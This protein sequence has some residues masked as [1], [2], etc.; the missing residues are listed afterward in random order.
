MPLVNH[1]ILQ[2]KR[3]I[4][5]SIF[6]YQLLLRISFWLQERFGRTRLESQ[7]H[8]LQH[9]R[10]PQVG[11]ARMT[12]KIAT[13]DRKVGDLEMMEEQQ[14]RTTMSI[15]Y[16]IPHLF[17]FFLGL[18]NP[19]INSFNHPLSPVCRARQ[20][21][22]TGPVRHWVAW[23]VLGNLLWCLMA[24]RLNVK[25]LGIRQ[26]GSLLSIPK[27][28]TKCD[29]YLAGGDWNPWNFEWLSRNSWE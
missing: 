18:R 27:V 6:L 15:L 7:H 16:Q 21:G 19:Q 12:P 22:Q 29:I 28:L 3:G 13:S 14:H 8:Q 9:C 10:A 26:W 20:T 24:E 25:K 17:H 1:S 11:D 4:R 23:P 2:P 5:W